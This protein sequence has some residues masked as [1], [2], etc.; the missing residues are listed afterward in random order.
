VHIDL[1][2]LPYLQNFGH[3]SLCNAPLPPLDDGVMD[4]RMFCS[5]KCTLL[6]LAGTSD[7]SLDT[8]FIC[9]VCGRTKRR[10]QTE[11]DRDSGELIREDAICDD[12]ALPEPPKITQDELLKLEVQNKFKN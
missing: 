1:T 6:A 11:I 9:E 2:K 3:C 8:H 10:T 7:D 12:C 5:G 4:D